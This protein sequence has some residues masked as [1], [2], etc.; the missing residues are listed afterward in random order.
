MPSDPH[1]PLRDDV[2]LLGDLLGDTLRAQ[3]GEKVFVRSSGCARSPK[4]RGPA[5]TKT[6]PRWRRS[7]HACRSTRPPG[8][9]RVRALPEPR[10]HRR[11]ASPHPAPAR[12]PARSGA[13]PQRGSCADAFARLIAGR[14][15]ARS[16]ARGGLRAADRAGAHGA[17][18][19]NRAP[20]AGAEIQPH[21]RRADDA[22]SP[23]LTMPEQEESLASLRREIATAWDTSE[24]RARAPDAARRSPERPDRLRAEPVGRAAALPSRGRSRARRDAPGAACRSRPRRSD[25]DP[26]SAAIATA[27]RM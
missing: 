14:H 16:A 20:H 5:V 1:K 2:R 23:D 9:A 15:H 13:A 18:D 10:Q 11:A 12:L 21:R 3:A 25:S 4:P 8:R 17:S 27:T 24:V 6:L 22:R 19:R 26:G 7:C